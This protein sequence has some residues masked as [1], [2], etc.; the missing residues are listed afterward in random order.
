M[1]NPIER[2]C[3]LMHMYVTPNKCNAPCGQFADATLD[4]LRGTVPKNWSRFR[5][6]VTDNF[7]VIS[8]K[9]FRVTT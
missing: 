7:R 3:G 5:D 2:L 8:P 6:S 9:V 1:M 4:V